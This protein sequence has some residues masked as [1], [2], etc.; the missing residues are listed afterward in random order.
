ML[1]IRLELIWVHFLSTS[2][3]IHTGNAAMGEGGVSWTAFGSRK[4]LQLVSP[5]SA[6]LLQIISFLD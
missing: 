6:L 3:Y 1:L 2:Q 5:V 4:L